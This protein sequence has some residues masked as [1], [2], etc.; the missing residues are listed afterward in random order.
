MALS[1]DTC[2]VVMS[3]PWYNNYTGYVKVYR[4]D[5][6]GGNRFQLSKTIYGNATDDWFG[7][8]VYI[9]ANGMTIVCGSPSSSEAKDQP[10]YARVFSLV[11]SNDDLNTATWEQIGQ[12]IIGEANGNWFGQSV[13]IFED[14]KTITISA[15]FNDVNNGANLGHVRIY[16]L[17]ENNGTRWEQ[18][19]DDI[20]GDAAGDLSGTFVSLLANGTIVAIGAPQAGI[21]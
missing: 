11:G 12:D 18:I 7:L 21:N 14:G 20:D 8:S 19:G 17:K 1:N 5:N 13:S 9:T 3:A 16:R 10:G 6:D 15:N 4:T 2:T